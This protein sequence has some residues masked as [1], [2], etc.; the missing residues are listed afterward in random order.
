VIAATNKDVHKC[1]ARGSFREDLYYR[2]NVVTIHLPPLR[3]RREDIPLLA[4]HFLKKFAAENQKEVS[5]FSPE[6]TDFLLKYPWPGNVR[7]LENTVERAVILAQN[8]NIEMANLLQKSSPLV[9]SARPGR[10]LGE[11]ERQ[12]I[13]N[14]LS[15]TDG[16]YSKTARILGISRATLYHKAKAYGLGVKKKDNS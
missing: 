1:I 7:E 9:S 16:N 12:H 5:G 8:S 14:I 15:E 13:L 10:K 3:E 11:V 6:V 4:H 2:L